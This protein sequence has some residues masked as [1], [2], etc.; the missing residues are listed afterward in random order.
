[1][2][3]Q[4]EVH[5]IESN[6]LGLRSRIGDHAGSDSVLNCLWDIVLA[7]EIIQE[8]IQTRKFINECEVV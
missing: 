7:Q 8:V 5:L 2:S 3:V 4:L 1:M 6:A